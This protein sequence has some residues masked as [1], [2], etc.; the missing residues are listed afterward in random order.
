[1]DIY[2]PGIDLHLDLH[3]ALALVVGLQLLAVVKIIAAPFRR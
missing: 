2:L 3:L 1:V